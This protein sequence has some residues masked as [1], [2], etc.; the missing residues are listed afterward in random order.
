MSRRRAQPAWM[1][2][3]YGFLAAL[4]AGSRDAERPNAGRCCTRSCRRCTRVSGWSCD[5]ER[6]KKR[7][8]TCDDVPRA[9]APCISACPRVHLDR[10]P[11][12]SPKFLF[13]LPPALFPLYTVKEELRFL[14]RFP[15][16]A[17]P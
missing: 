15:T 6:E 3:S 5:R 7:A 13:L 11:T 8:R 12:K 10:P 17:N 1:R 2:S 16:G 9:T 14:F 4:C